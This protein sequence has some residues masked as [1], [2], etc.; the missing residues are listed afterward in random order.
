MRTPV[1]MLTTEASNRLNIYFS[2]RVR[3]GK[4]RIY[5]P[6][7]R[8]GEGTPRAHHTARPGSLISTA[9]A[10]GKQ[11]VSFKQYRAKTPYTP[12][13]AWWRNKKS[14]PRCS[15]RGHHH[16]RLYCAS[17][18]FG[19]RT[20]S[21]RPAT[22][23]VE[24]TSKSEKEQILSHPDDEPS[25]ADDV[26]VD[27]DGNAYVTDT[28]ANKIWKVGS[29]GELLSIIRNNIFVQKKEWY[30]NF[31]GLNGIVYH[32]NGYLLVIHT[33][34]GYLFKVDIKT[35]DVRVVQVTGSLLL[36]DGLELLS[37]TKLVVAGTPSARILESFDDWNTATVTERFI[38]PLH[39]IATSATVKEGKVYLNHLLGLGVTRRTHVI[40]AA[41]FTALKAK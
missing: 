28:K 12:L 32:Q 5:T 1:L 23:A 22:I 26:A 37:P 17:C 38:G 33:A 21:N 41:D 3:T 6:F 15:R 11:I 2:V 36:G 30:R 8:G 34:G 29:N 13:C 4:R 18:Q 7:A 40:T 31:V 14:R 10:G 20:I 27:D 9:R 35:E 19:A 16:T 25:Y 39:R 24:E